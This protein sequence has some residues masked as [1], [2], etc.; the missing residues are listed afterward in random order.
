MIFK[1]REVVLFFGNGVYKHI[2][3]GLLALEE[4]YIRHPKE[5]QDEHLQPYNHLF[6]NRYKSKQINK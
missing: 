2:K 5:I 3:W 1:A 4:T 6:R